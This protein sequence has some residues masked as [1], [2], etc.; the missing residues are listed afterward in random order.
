MP[1]TLLGWS[2]I[3]HNYSTDSQVATAS[4]AMDGRRVLRLLTG[5]QRTQRRCE[6]D[7]R[8]SAPKSRTG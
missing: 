5:S 6:L 2:V 3:H 1:G 7:G 4:E 8:S